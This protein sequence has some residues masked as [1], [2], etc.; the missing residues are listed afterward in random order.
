MSV[1]PITVGEETKAFG[2]PFVNILSIFGASQG[3]LVYL[4]RTRIPVSANWFGAPGAHPYGLVAL[5]LLGYVG[6]GALGMAAFSD[7]NLVR[8]ANAHRRDRVLLTDGQH[9]RNYDY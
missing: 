9:L 7:W 6:G 1:R 4:H 2:H 3:L 8:L 5:L